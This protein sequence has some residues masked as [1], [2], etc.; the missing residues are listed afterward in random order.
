MSKKLT[1]YIAAS[2]AQRIEAAALAELLRDT[3]DVLSTWHAGAPESFDDDGIRPPRAD[4][5]NSCREIA[6]RDLNQV[7]RAQTLIQITGGPNRGGR[8]V[9]LGVALALFAES[10]ATPFG[11]PYIAVLGPHE[12]VFHLHPAVDCWN[13]P[14]EL[15]FYLFL[16]A[17]KFAQAQEELLHNETGIPT[18]GE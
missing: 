18:N 9:E 5:W 15:L 12:H 2:W 1:L 14:M 3:Y 17:N 10:A 11:K 16:R 6:I 13:N 4:E 8:Q 7:A